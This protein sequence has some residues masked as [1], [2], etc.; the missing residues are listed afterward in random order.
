MP[1]ELWTFGAAPWLAKVGPWNLTLEV[2]EDKPA[3]AMALMQGQ[4]LPTVLPVVATVLWCALFIGV[5]QDLA[6]SNSSRRMNPFDTPRVVAHSRT[7]ARLLASRASAKRAKPVADGRDFCWEGCGMETGSVFRSAFWV[8]FGLLLLMRVYYS[9]RVRRAGERLLPDQAAVEREGRAAFAVRFAAFF[10]LIAILVLYTI[11]HPW[12]A[13]LSIPLPS[14]LRWVGFALGLLS[15]AFW[16]WTQA[17][18]GAHWSAQLQ[19]R[20]EHHLVTTGPYARVRH[21][22][23]TGM[24]AWAVGVAL[25]TANWV[26]VV[27]TALSLV[28]LAVRVPREEQMMLDEFGDEYRAYMHR[29]GRFVPKSRDTPWTPS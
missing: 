5:A 29:T 13:T 10:V 19:L 11:N 27:F 7:T 1:R 12:M 21:P 15:L 14:W 3:L 26:F 28:G 23:Y 25:V 4:R 9:L 2:G 20:E 8:L 24:I 22:L 16:T 6:L 18:L 17:A